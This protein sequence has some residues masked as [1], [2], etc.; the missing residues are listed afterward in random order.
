M[1]HWNVP[2][3]NSAG[4][5]QCNKRAVQIQQIAEQLRKTNQNLHSWSGV[6]HVVSVSSDK[7]CSEIHHQESDV[8]NIA[9][10]L[11]LV[12]PRIDVLQNKNNNP[13]KRE[14]Y[15]MPNHHFNKTKLEWKFVW[16]Q[17]NTVSAR[18]CSSLRCKGG[19]GG[20][21]TPS[22]CWSLLLWL[23]P[24]ISC[25]ACISNTRAKQVLKA[26]IADVGW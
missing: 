10:V 26:K 14:C 19:R 16:R 13:S 25:L 11:L 20:R 24:L 12:E 8:S 1:R 22:G 2:S 15:H 23:Y 4:N 9:L 3:N 6:R 5:R 7:V 21:R 18:Q 17:K